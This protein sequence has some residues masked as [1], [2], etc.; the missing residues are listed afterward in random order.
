MRILCSILAIGVSKMPWTLN[1]NVAESS[2]IYQSLIAVC[3]PDSEKRQRKASFSIAADFDAKSPTAHNGSHSGKMAADKSRSLFVFFLIFSGL[4]LIH[5]FWLFPRGIRFL[6]GLR[7]F[8][9]PCSSRAERSFEV[10][11]ATK[12]L[13][14]LLL[15]Y[16][17][18]PARR[19]AD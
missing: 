4:F 10:L 12:G 17:Y 18:H 13:H 6:S 2:I 5:L 9:G 8:D 1:I 19:K 14:G 16:R 11:V 3:L 15:K 7:V